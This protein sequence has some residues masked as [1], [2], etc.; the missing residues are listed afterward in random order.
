M[1][2]KS[3]LVVILAAAILVSV[4]GCTVGAPENTSAEPTG[5]VLSPSWAEAYSSVKEMTAHA[6]AVVVGKV[7]NAL[8]TTVKDGIPY[9]DFTYE[10]QT[11]V[12]GKH[13]ASS[14][15]QIHQTGGSV[16]GMIEVVDGDPLLVVGQKSLLYLRQYEE[17]KYFIIGGP[18]GRMLV[19]KEN[20]VSPMP[21]GAAR[22][23]L[24]A[25][26]PE[27]LNRVEALAAESGGQ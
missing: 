6:D 18:T 27:F 9:T 13:L 14:E 8:G 10:V 17:G 15:I 16:D 2:L 19:D 20:K 11:S 1:N 24:P 26:L 3:E 5:K 23:G 12:K 7:T 25:Q 22:D 4:S 21:E